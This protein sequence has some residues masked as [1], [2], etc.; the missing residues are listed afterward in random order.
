MSFGISWPWAGICNFK[1]SDSMN[2]C[3]SIRETTSNVNVKEALRK[4]L[5]SVTYPFKLIYFFGA[6]ATYKT[7][8]FI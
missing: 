3:K 8:S 6:G 4:R 5:A 2:L 1:Y 7:F